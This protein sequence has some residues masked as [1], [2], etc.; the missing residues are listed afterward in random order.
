ML[1]GIHL[2]EKLIRNHELSMDEYVKLLEQ[3]QN[4][5]IVKLLADEAVRLRKQ[6]YGDKV[7]TRGLIEFTNLQKQL[8]LLRNPCRKPQCSP[9][10]SD[11]RGDSFL[12]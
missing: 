9:I 11:R 10:S 12:L 6:Y 8:L 2:A 4:Q 7:Y 5:D 3:Y 1:N